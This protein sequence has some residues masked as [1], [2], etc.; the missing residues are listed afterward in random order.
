MPKIQKMVFSDVGIEHF[1]QVVT[2]EL[3]R[4]WKF[5]PTSLHVSDSRYCVILEK[6][7]D[8]MEEKP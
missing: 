6:E 1:N 3:A 5:V 2:V 4:G 7:F 8:P